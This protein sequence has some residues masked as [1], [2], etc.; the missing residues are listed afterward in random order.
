MTHDQPVK[1]LEIADIF[2]KIIYICYNDAGKTN[3][4]VTRK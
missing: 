1:L 4:H 3:C 2:L